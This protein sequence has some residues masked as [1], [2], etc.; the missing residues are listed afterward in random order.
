[1]YSLPSTKPSLILAPENKKN[2]SLSLPEKSL[3]GSKLHFHNTF[4]KRI[5]EPSPMSN[6]W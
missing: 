1:M 4:N 5:A 6:K 3:A 2:C